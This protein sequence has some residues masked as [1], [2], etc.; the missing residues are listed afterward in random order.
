MFSNISIG[1]LTKY[2]TFIQYKEKKNISARHQLSN[3]FMNIH[4]VSNDISS[5]KKPFMNIL[6][7]LQYNSSWAANEQ[8]L[9]VSSVLLLRQW[10]CPY[11]LKSIYTRPP[12]LSDCDAQQ[13]C[14]H[15][16]GLECNI[17]RLLLFCVFLL[18]ILIMETLAFIHYRQQLA[19]M[20]SRKPE[21]SYDCSVISKRITL[22]SWAFGCWPLVGPLALW[23]LG[24]L[25][26]LLQ[27]VSL[28][29]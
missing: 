29:L 6:L 4:I 25:H 7:K 20:Q 27:P 13:Q 3:A 12:W 15:D 9:M 18:I 21:H 5:L 10:G 28:L 19:H 23:S 24:F 2:F 16:D 11:L 1:L 8:C 26:L 22:L 17:K 14:L